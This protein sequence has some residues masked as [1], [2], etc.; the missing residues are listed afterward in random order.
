VGTR[1]HAEARNLLLSVAAGHVTQEQVDALVGAVL[2]APDF[3]LALE[4]QAGGPL[5]VRRAVALAGMLL[6]AAQAALPASQLA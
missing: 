3:A 6:D 2:G 4:V 5:A 1:G